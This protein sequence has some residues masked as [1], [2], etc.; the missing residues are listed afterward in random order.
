MP[1][2]SA[3]GT[4]PPVAPPPEGATVDPDA[5]VDGRH[6]RWD[7]HRSSRRA[8]LVR[9]ARR[10]V[11]HLGPE[12]SM[13][14]LAAEMGTSKSIIY[15]Y[16]T[17]KSG[18]QAAVGGAVIDGLRSAIA[19]ATAG[20]TRPREQIA[21]MIEVY[22]GVVETSAHVYAFVTQ[23]E[24]TATAG[25]L[26]GFIAETEDIVADALL[27][28]LGP[29]GLDDGDRALAALWASGV[30][31]LARASVER[32]IAARVD[33]APT[34]HAADGPPETDAGHGIEDVIAGL[35]RAELAAHLTDWAWE[36]AAGIARRVRTGRESSVAPAPH[37]SPPPA[38]DTEHR[39][40]HLA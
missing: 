6:A 19:E 17:D 12:L 23:P 13:D 39:S 10:A 9:A 21:A 7:A 29:T 8:E 20:L 1:S 18:L 31:G 4:N 27:P 36:G 38:P 32:W 35:D 16:F 11:H 3:A 34:D 40:E 37:Q 33:A 15:R 28:V 2:T 25:A 24:A 22:L 14:E 30:V 5:R 26:R